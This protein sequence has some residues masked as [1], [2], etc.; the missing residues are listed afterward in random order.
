[1][2]L[3]SSASSSASAS[4]LSRFSSFMSKRK[5]WSWMLAITLV[6]LQVSLC[7]SKEDDKKR[8]STS[9]PTFAPTP[10]PTTTPTSLPSTRPTPAPTERRDEKNNDKNN[11]KDADWDK[12]EL[13]EETDPP[14]VVPVAQ[15][16]AVPVAPPSAFIAATSPP[17]LP[18]KL[19]MAPIIPETLTTALPTTPP[20]VED[21]PETTLPTTPPFVAAVPATSGPSWWRRPTPEP[22]I[23]KS[24]SVVAR[25][26][27]DPAQTLDKSD[28]GDDSNGGEDDG[29]P[30]LFTES[31]TI[32]I[33]PITVVFEFMPQAV[34]A[35]EVS[36]ATGTAVS[37]YDGRRHLN[38]KKQRL[39]VAMERELI[40]FLTMILATNTAQGDSLTS[41]DLS[42][43]ISYEDEDI[44]SSSN[45][46]SAGAAF[47]SGT[48][49]FT[50]QTAELPTEASLH[51]NLVL[52]FQ[53]WGA[54]NLLKHL[55]DNN[56]DVA[57][58][59]VLVDGLHVGSS[60][61]AKDLPGDNEQQGGASSSGEVPPSDSTGQHEDDDNDDSNKASLYAGL[62]MGFMLMFVITVTVLFLR[63]RKE[64]S[65]VQLEREQRS[66]ASFP[67]K[68][69][70]MPERLGSP[71]MTMSN[72][73][74]EHNNHHLHHDPADE[75]LS[76]S[77]AASGVVVNMT[78]FHELHHEEWDAPEEPAVVMGSPPVSSLGRDE[79]ESEKD[80]FDDVD[81]DD[82]EEA[83][84]HNNDSLDG[85]SLFTGSVVTVNSNIMPPPRGA[86]RSSAFQYDPSRLSSVISS[87]RVY[88]REME[89]VTSDSGD[90]SD[91]S[92]DRK[93]F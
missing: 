76:S 35:L 53:F 32:A 8:R 37:G 54:G 68:V 63:H 62:S 43:T 78:N 74:E 38:D 17:S 72:S 91:K 48:A 5:G 52:Y 21:V 29:T 45:S 66:A 28:T 64:S 87:A 36:P 15:P 75:S 39:E 11:D 24:P 82:E 57:R 2:A 70:R 67:A 61:D 84:S 59:V 3:G 44:V 7:L 23:P 58:V 4:A 77:S 13:F 50:G 12:P 40:S 60:D 34:V 19:T 42:V 20:F 27:A 41:T 80:A 46:P 88:A 73:S 85:S 56:I 25:P 26:T 90:S 79:S 6:A 69:D 49:L 86:L 14:V 47:V 30:S 33:P 92:G 71:I 65:T 10:F 55:V 83:N 81:I 16:A 31:R 1:M 51:E 22:Q 18:Q 89:T 93:S 9:A